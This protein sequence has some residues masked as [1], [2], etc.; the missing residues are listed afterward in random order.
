MKE[1]S[2]RVL[3]KIPECRQSRGYIIGPMQTFS[4]QRSKRCIFGKVLRGPVDLYEKC[5]K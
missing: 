5:V 4:V 2:L 1:I 3:A